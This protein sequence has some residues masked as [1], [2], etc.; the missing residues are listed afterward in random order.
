MS[1]FYLSGDVS[2]ITTG[3]SSTVYVIGTGANAPEAIEWYRNWLSEGYMDGSGTV[4]IENITATPV[5]DQLVTE[6]G[7]TPLDWAAMIQS[8]VI[9]EGAAPDDFDA[10]Y[11]LNC[12]ELVPAGKLP[13]DPESFRRSL[14]AGDAADLNWNPEKN[15]LFVIKAVREAI[16]LVAMV[17]ARNAPMAAWSWRHHGWEVAMSKY[18]IMVEPCCQILQICG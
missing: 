17:K 2:R 11:W 4:V 13:P 12:Q 1:A 3:A 7:C 5:F 8:Q 18:P 10:G 15:H 6:A 16:E 14:S 9:P